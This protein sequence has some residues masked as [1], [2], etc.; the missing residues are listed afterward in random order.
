MSVVAVDKCFKCTPGTYQNETGCTSACKQCELGTFQAEDGALK[1]NP[2]S[3]G[4]FSKEVEANNRVT[5]KRCEPQTFQNETGQRVY[6][7]DPLKI[8]KVKCR[9][10]NVK[11]SSIR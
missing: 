10:N 8:C 9:T 1:C 2:C 7:K 3:F 11:R 5:C 4:T 6:A